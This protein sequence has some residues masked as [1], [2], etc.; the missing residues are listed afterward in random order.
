MLGSKAYLG[1]VMPSFGRTSR[2]RLATCH[3]DIRKIFNEVVKVMD[4]K[5]IE[6]ART[7]AQQRKNIAKG[8]S[9]TMKS[10]HVERPCRALDIVPYPVDWE[11]IYRFKVFT[12]Y[13]FAVSRRLKIPLKYGGTWSR[14]PTGPFKGVKANPDWA[15]F[16]LIP[17]V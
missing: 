10:K 9:W 7:K 15:H 3:K 8:V 11:D 12:A 5:V 4:C 6:G 14:N 13:V 2:N 17:K 16:E 1:V